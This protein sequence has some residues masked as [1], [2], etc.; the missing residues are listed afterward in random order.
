MIYDDARE[1]WASDLPREQKYILARLMFFTNKGSATVWPSVQR[2]AE[3]TGHS[4][5]VVQRALAGL[6]TAGV[7][8]VVSK[9]SQH[10]PTE[11][12]IHFERLSPRP[13]K[14]PLRGDVD[15][16]PIHLT[17]VT[18]T[19]PLEGPR[20]DADES[21][22]EAPG[23]TYTTPRG[24][25]HDI[26]G[27]TYTT[28]KQ[29]IEQAINKREKAAAAPAGARGEIFTLYQQTVGTI[30]P[31]IFQELQEAEDEYT[32]ECVKHSFAEASELNKRSWRYVKAILIR[33]KAEGCFKPKGRA[34]EAVSGAAVPDEPIV[35]PPGG[36]RRDNPK[37][38]LLEQHQLTQRAERDASAV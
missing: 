37:H 18:P 23:V 17:G 38:R 35:T 25:V 29:T 30:D 31:H 32:P 28:P 11:Y 2:V 24:D 20:G 12:R 8:E 1:L 22:D 19:P 7:L 27:V 3:D 36:W 16:T 33:H 26:P 5:R 15:A 14:P 21:S 9:A 10:H 6:R 34:N 13:S 4:K